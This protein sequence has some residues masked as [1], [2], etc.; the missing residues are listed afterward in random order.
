M[1]REA[2]QETRVRGLMVVGGKL[3]RRAR[4]RAW[5]DAWRNVRAPENGTLYQPAARVWGPHERY[6]ST[7]WDVN[8]WYFPFIRELADSTTATLERQGKQA[9]EVVGPYN[10]RIRRLQ[11]QIAA[12]EANASTRTDERDTA[13]AAA[14]DGERG[15]K[16]AFRTAAHP[17]A[18]AKRR[19][20]AAASVAAAAQAS[21]SALRSE[22]EE[23]IAQRMAAVAPLR[24]EAL[25]THAL[26]ESCQHA[27]LAWRTRF[28]R[29]KHGPPPPAHYLV[30]GLPAWVVFDEALYDTDPKTTTTALGGNTEEAV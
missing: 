19:A 22:L 14:S 21:A 23:S 20:R 26:G 11:A 6:P 28:S 18:Q 5:W 16:P 15:N 1:V 30:V 27:Y 29:R 12:A 25:A 8:E 7:V 10:A 4:R 17:N 3:E 2:G 9:H 13:L 24:Q